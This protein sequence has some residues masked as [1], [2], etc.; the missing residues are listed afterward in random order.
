MRASSESKSVSAETDTSK[1]TGPDHH[2]HH[3][4]DNRHT[5]L[6]LSNPSQRQPLQPF[7]VCAG[8]PSGFVEAGAETERERE[9]DWEDIEEKV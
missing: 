2:H 3:H 4:F 5:S 8:E 7:A 1:E 9:L 6:D